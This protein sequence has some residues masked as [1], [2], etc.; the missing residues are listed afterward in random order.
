MKEKL[1]TIKQQASQ[2]AEVA[3]EE[4]K[5]ESLSISP[6]RNAKY[7]DIKSRVYDPPKPRIQPTKTRKSTNQERG[8]W[9]ALREKRGQ[10]P[11]KNASA[12]DGGEASA[13]RTTPAKKADDKES[14]SKKK[15]R[16]HS[17]SF[18]LQ[19]IQNS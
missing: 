3:K 5:S 18:N 17:P 2:A 4:N 10:S 16:D 19:A 6:S 8:R 13:K 12:G 15:G 9:S 7:S 1:A 11:S 14:P